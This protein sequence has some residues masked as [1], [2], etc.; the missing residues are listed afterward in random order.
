MLAA[1]G[2]PGAG[3]QRI[4]GGPAARSPPGCQSGGWT[5]FTGKRQ[6]MAEGVLDHLLLGAAE[7]PISAN[8]LRIRQP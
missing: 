7:Y 6:G 5:T 4:G 1:P 8:L 2:A 3:R